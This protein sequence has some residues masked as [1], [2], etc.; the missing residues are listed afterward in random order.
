MANK[1]LNNRVIWITGAS[2]GIGASLVQQCAKCGA[3]VVLSSRREEELKNVALKAGL[4]DARS[5][6][7]PFDMLD[8]ESF[9]AYVEKVISR[10][11][12][13]DI[14]V[15]NAGRS[16]R[17]FAV[18]TQEQV[19]RSLF[20]LNYFSQVALTKAILPKMIENK[21]GKIVVVSSIAGKFGFYLRSTYCATK[22]A[23]F[24][25]FEALRLEQEKNGISVMFVCPGK[26]KTN[27]SFNAATK[28][29]SIFGKVSHGYETTTD[30]DTCAKEIVKGI[31][32]N[33]QE[34]FVG[35]REIWLV[36]FKR[37]IPFLFYKIVR[38]RNPYS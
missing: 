38:N 7:L 25:Y 16:Q 6:I 1:M 12:R 8:K 5:L 28:D 37:F 21:S 19:E 36:Y 13:I 15:N 11:G 3:M 31:L 35:G 2:S 27:A 32:A 20:E 26:I 22:H 29:G 10:F 9:P 18:E 23:L 30:A 33:K 17:S 34:I 24:G 14:L 4:T